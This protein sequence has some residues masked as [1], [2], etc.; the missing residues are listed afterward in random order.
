MLPL[1]VAISAE[2]FSELNI[3]L[4]PSS[5]QFGHLFVVQVQT[6]SL[7]TQSMGWFIGWQFSSLK[8]SF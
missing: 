3:L 5:S 1:E 8:I 7:S 6:F 2:M 4:N